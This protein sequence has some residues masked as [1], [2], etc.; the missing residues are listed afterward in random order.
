VSDLRKLLLGETRALPLGIAAI[1]AAALA[2]NAL[3][4]S[5]WPEVA[6]WAVLATTVALAVASMLLS[7][8]VRRP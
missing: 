8:G 2:L 5:W 4:G 7:A 6:G 1:A 3:A